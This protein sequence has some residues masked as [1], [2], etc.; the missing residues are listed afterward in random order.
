MDP[1][2]LALSLTNLKSAELTTRIQY[3]VAA[4]VLKLADQQGA[5]VVQLLRA[6]T[7]NFDDSLARANTATD[8]ARLLDAYA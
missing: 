7:E 8:P 4:R 5:G 1:T 2:E 3:A 6:A